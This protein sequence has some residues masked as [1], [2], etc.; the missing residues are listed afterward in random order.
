MEQSKET[1]HAELLKTY[2]FDCQ[3]PACVSNYQLPNKLPRI[4]KSFALPNFG[5]F[6]SNRDLMTELKQNFKF[7]EE[8]IQ[9]HPCF[10]ICAFVIRNREVIKVLGERATYP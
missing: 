2:D 5:H 3:C 9:H 10:E 4:K 8:N 1:R 7:I 6:E